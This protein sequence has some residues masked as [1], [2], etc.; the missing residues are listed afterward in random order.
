MKKILLTA[1]LFVSLMGAKAQFTHSA[2]ASLFLASSDVSGSLATWGATYYPRYCV[3]PN[4]SV[5][6]PLSLGLALSASSGSGGSSSGS[7]I[8]LQ[9]PVVADY[10]VGLGAGEEGEDA[11]FGA[12]GG[13]GFGYFVTAYSATD[14]YGDAASGNLTATGPYLHAGIRFK[15]KDHAIDLGGSYHK[16]LGGEKASIVGISLLYGL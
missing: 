9:L 14:S 12:Y 10:N 3:S 15:V 2:G 5:G 16:G 13:V 8:T 1:V 6:I 11:G 4:I 7:A